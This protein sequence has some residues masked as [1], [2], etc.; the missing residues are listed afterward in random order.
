MTCVSVRMSHHPSMRMPHA[1]IDRYIDI[2]ICV[3]VVSLFL[4]HMVVVH[5]HKPL[6]KMKCLCVRYRIISLVS[7]SIDAMGCAHKESYDRLG[8]IDG[9][10]ALHECATRGFLACATLL[11]DH[12]AHLDRSDTE[13]STPCM[14]AVTNGETAMV[15]FLLSRGASPDIKNGAGMTALHYAASSTHPP[16]T[17]AQLIRLLC[18]ANADVNAQTE[19]QGQTALHMTCASDDHVEGTTTLLSFG[20]NLDCVDRH[21]NQVSIDYLSIDISIDFD[22]YRSMCS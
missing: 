18:D 5:R 16:A 1:D 12:G 20:A 8:T 3:R 2:S 4:S 19:R 14:Y 21:G 7:S 11:L 10:T 13:G 15:S 6:L 17:V 9:T 22:R